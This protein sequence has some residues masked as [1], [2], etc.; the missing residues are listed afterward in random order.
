MHILLIAY[1]FPPSPSPQS[2]RWAYLA[3]HLADRGHR[4]SV[5]TIH[6]GGETPG[7]PPLP[8]SIAVHRT[9][10]GPIRG[11]LAA[12]RD[13]RARAAGA[14]RPGP[15]TP[16]RRSRQGWKQAVSD[17]L[18]SAAARIVFPDVR[19]EWQPW[20]RRR[21]RGILHADRPDLV[22]SSHEPA[23]SLE[24]GILA[25]R[26]GLPWIA[27]LGDPVLAPYTPPRWR[28][29]AWALERTVSDEA[30]HLFVT[31]S[32]AA[33]LLEERHARHDRI[34]VVTQGHAGAIDSSSG[35]IDFDPTRLEL[36]YTGSFYSFRRPEALLAALRTCPGARLNIAAVTLPESV[37][38]FASEFPDRIRLLGFLPH[39][40]AL[41]FQRDADL[42]VNIGNA[43][44]SQVPGKIYEYLGACRP[45]LHLGDGDD[46]IARLLSYLHR[47]WT[48][49][50]DADAIAALL[51]RLVETKRSGVFTDGLDLT[52]ATVAEWRWEHL[53][54]RVE[55]VAASLVGRG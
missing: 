46:A 43:D 39:N 27:D 42:L 40:D 53:A 5:L 32:A 38:G 23:T 30:D 50:N 2:L 14:S 15:A 26:A 22:I 6:L 16:A 51:D 1:E 29:R 18:Q 55:A 41:A 7:L 33:A 20:A 47:G 12:L 19:G 9:F 24:L 10:A 44:P 54:S 3:R 4:I 31:T 35:R 52:A 36:L 21:L 25:K 37:L 8:S 45:I 28:A 49:D 48:T 34:T 11:A 13:R 17:A